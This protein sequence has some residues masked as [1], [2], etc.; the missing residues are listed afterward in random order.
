M[1]PTAT[2][3]L[4]AALMCAAAAQLQPPPR[5]RVRRPPRQPPSPGAND[6]SRFPL[7]DYCLFCSDSGKLVT[8]LSDGGTPCL[9]R[10]AWMCAALG[11]DAA[12]A[13]APPRLPPSK[14]LRRPAHRMGPRP[15]SSA[16]KCKKPRASRELTAA[17]RAFGGARS[18][19]CSAR[20]S[21]GCPAAATRSARRKVS[22]RVPAA[23]P[24]SAA[25]STCAALLP[26]PGLARTCTAHLL[27][28]HLPPTLQPSLACGWWAAPMPT[29]A[30]WRFRSEATGAPC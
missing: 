29:A 22:P 28:C 3:V 7:N 21:A 9:V 13:A 8:C 27:P 26:A 10:L 1:K 5:R 17:T 19:P 12:S 30:E 25:M 14:T 11:R 20:G 23:L 24:A 18:P 6:C 2:A 4:L 15:S 16:R